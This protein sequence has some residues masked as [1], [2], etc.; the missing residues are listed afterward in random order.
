M[1]D[2]PPKLVYPRPASS[3]LCFIARSSASAS[4]IGGAGAGAGALSAGAGAGAGAG[5]LSAGAGAGVL[6]AGAGA[7]AGA[8]GVLNEEPRIS[9]S[10]KSGVFSIG[11]LD[12]AFGNEGSFAREPIFC[13]SSTN[14]L[15]AARPLSSNEGPLSRTGSFISKLSIEPSGVS[16][17]C[18]SAIAVGSAVGAIVSRSASI[19]SAAACVC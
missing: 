8:T 19:A 15:A 9:V 13:K 17:R 11:I 12:L 6:S 14:P 10:A 7:G 5:V 2:S 3:E 16:S 1:L 18:R 4:D